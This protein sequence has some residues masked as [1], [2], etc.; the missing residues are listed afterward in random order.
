MR[1][2]PERLGEHGLREASR[3]PTCLQPDTPSWRCRRPARRRRHPAEKRPPV[4]QPTL[5]HCVHWTLDTAR[6]LYMHAR[7]C[8]NGGGQDGTARKAV[9]R[10]H[11]G[12][13]RMF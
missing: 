4:S 3:L 1:D 11:G 12:S 9:S 13:K 10:W 5:G 2:R 8:G 6:N 7:V